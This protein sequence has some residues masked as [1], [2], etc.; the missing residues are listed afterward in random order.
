MSHK[1]QIAYAEKMAVAE[2]WGPFDLSEEEVAAIRTALE[3]RRA[4]LDALKKIRTMGY[5][6]DAFRGPDT[7]LACIR[8]AEE[9][10]GAVE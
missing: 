2:D 8:I 5:D 7:V 9:V 10:I 6:S 4:L 3:D 1:E